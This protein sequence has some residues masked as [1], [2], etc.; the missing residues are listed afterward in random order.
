VFWF[1]ELATIEAREKD[2]NQWHIKKYAAKYT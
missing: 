1:N 2:K